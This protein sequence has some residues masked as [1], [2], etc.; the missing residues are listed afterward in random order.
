MRGEG[1]GSWLL[2]ATVACGVC[3]GGAACSADVFDVAV[4]LQPETLVLDFGDAAGTIPDVPCD[5]AAPACTGAVATAAAA[6]SGVPADVTVSLGCDP[7][8]ARC[9]AQ[10]D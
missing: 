9:F 2:A 7:D 4:D 10:A 5:P 3:L 1:A 6:P 8:R